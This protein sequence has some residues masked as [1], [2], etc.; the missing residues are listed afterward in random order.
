VVNN[1]LI[2]GI[3]SMSEPKIVFDGASLITPSAITAD[4]EALHPTRHSDGQ[5]ATATAELGLVLH[6]AGQWFEAGNDP[7]QTMRWTV[8]ALHKLRRKVTPDV[9]RALIPIAQDHAAAHYFHQDPFTRWSFEK[10][11]GY[12][13]DARLL[14]FIYQHETIREDVEQASPIGSALYAYSKYYPS[15]I[16]VRERRDLLARYVDEVADERGA[17][18][19]ILAIASGHLRE[20]AGSAALARGDITRWVALDQDPL[21]VGSVAR[22]YAGTPVQALDGSVRGL[23]GDK[24][25]LGTFDFVY[26]AGLY[27]YLTDAVAMRLNRRCMRM[28]KPGGTLL[29]ANFSPELTDDGY[30]ETF[31]NWALL[32]R[33]EDDM[34]K[35]IN[36]SVDRNT[37]EAKVFFGENRNIIYG[38]IRKLD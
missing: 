15:C 18:T 11:R 37:V 17:G 10:P 27:D 38:V 13:G 32:L 5:L 9:W 26:S 19:E 31:M 30:M 33:T 8:E 20:A 14:D 3:N 24:Y 4:M 12:S 25:K 36:G 6:S 35:I 7:A 2:E 28:L 1:S 29:F 34:W 22:D 16:A 23:L 21:S